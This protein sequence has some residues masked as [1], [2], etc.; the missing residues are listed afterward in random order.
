MMH[1]LSLFYY[2]HK[3]WVIFK[4]SINEDEYL[5]DNPLK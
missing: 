2:K 3:Y 5:Q 1:S 4:N